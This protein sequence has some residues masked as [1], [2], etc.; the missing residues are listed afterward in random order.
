MLI[1][2]V[3]K[4]IEF[5]CERKDK[6]DAT[7]IF[8]VTQENGFTTLLDGIGSNS[9]SYHVLLLNHQSNNLVLRRY[10]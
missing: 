8:Y 1:T 5:R 9:R 2:W 7:G 6:E 10:K 3:K 4:I